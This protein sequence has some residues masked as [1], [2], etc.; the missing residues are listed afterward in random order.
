MANLIYAIYYAFDQHLVKK[1]FVM[2]DYDSF[3]KELDVF[4][5]W[6]NLDISSDEIKAIIEYCKKYEDP[7]Y[8]AVYY[9]FLCG[10]MK[11]DSSLP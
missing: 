2:D 5:L 1:V 8:L 4:E 7:M 10:C 6:N 9:G 11:F 3:I